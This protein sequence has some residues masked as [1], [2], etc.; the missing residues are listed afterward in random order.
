MWWWWLNDNGQHL[1]SRSVQN[2]KCYSLLKSL[3]IRMN[4][5]NWTYKL[6]SDIVSPEGSIKHIFQRCYICRLK[7]MIRCNSQSLDHHKKKVVR[8]VNTWWSCSLWRFCSPSRC[9]PEKEN[10]EYICDK[11]TKDTSHIK[12]CPL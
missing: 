4:C 7:R 5:L 10:S 9:W 6:V 12:L 11:K 8:H 1:K 3:E 2:I